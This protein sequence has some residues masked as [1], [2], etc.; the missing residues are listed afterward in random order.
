M[1]EV[2]PADQLDRVLRLLGEM[3]AECDQT[4]RT[5]YMRAEKYRRDF[6]RGLAGHA[7][8]YAQAHKDLSERLRAL[9]IDTKGTAKC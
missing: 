9:I 1:Q 7:N 3:A 6:S 5:E 4:A 2:T 8:G